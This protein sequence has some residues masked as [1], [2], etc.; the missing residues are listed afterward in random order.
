MR[1]VKW[2]MY[3]VSKHGIPSK[4]NLY[5]YVYFGWW[6]PGSPRPSKAWWGDPGAHHPR[7]CCSAC[8]M[9]CWPV[10]FWRFVRLFWVCAFCCFHW[11]CRFVGLW[12]WQH[13]RTLFAYFVHDL[14]VLVMGLNSVVCVWDDCFFLW[15]NRVVFHALRLMG[16]TVQK[17]GMAP[18]APQSPPPP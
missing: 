17:H 13:F 14:G 6:H 1:L 8:M 9:L 7:I 5:G 16:V 3:G 15:C 2:S 11:F 4:F 12:V 10:D 18:A